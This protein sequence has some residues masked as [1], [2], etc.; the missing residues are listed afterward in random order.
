MLA[1]QFGSSSS[2]FL[3]CTRKAPDVVDILDIKRNEN[4]ALYLQW[5]PRESQSRKKQEKLI[6]TN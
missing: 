3:I 5:D 4:K 2:V 6:Y 1:E